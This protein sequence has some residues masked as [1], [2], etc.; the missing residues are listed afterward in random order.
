MLGNFNFF[1]VVSL[2]FFKINFFHKILSR[3]IPE[4]KT[5]WIQISPDVVSGLIWVQTICKNHQ[6]MT[7]FTAGRQSSSK[8]FHIFAG[9]SGG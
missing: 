1:F 9:S 4:C 3:T 8:T 5:V 7:K 6:Q 2:S